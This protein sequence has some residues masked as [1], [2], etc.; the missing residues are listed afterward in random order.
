MNIVKMKIGEISETMVPLYASC[1]SSE[2]KEI[3]SAMIWGP[4]GIGKSDIVREIG[5]QLQKLTGKTV[6]V[7]DVRLLL[8]NPIDLRG[9]PTADEKKETAKWLKPELFNLNANKN[10]INIIFL[11]EI[12]A[13]PPSVQA[14]AYQLTLDRKIGEHKLPDNTIIM[15]AG[16]RVTDKSVAYQMPKAL[17]NRFMHFEAICDVDD[18]KKWAIPHSID[19]RIIGF[20]NWKNS[21]LFDFDP[22]KDDLAFPTPRSWSKVSG[23]LNKIPDITNSYPLVSGLIGTGAATEFRAYCQLY[24]HLPNIE[25]IYNGKEVETPSKP[26]VLYALSA[27]LVSYAPKAN[28]K[29]LSNLLKYTM[30]MS[31]EYSTLTVKDLVKLESVRNQIL[32]LPEWIE[33]SSKHKEFI[34]D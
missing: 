5:G 26:D 18:W 21:A 32:M 15:A 16:N 34:L 19:S 2:Y 11:D 3:P 23:I 7:I 27:A 28:K 6:D 1:N 13:A 29:Q 17:A 20:I 31:A 10:H 25:D 14:A 4:P 33:W 9:I 30:T 24:K 22:S 12:S 8:F